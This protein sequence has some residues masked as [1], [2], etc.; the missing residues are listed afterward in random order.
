MIQSAKSIGENMTKRAFVPQ[1]YQLI[2]DGF[3]SEGF[4]LPIAPLSTN[5]TDVTIFYV[6]SSG[7][8]ITLAST[9]YVID[10][11]SEPGFI[12]ESY[13]NEWPDTYDQINAVMVQYITG[14]AIT[15]AVGLP[16]ASSTPEPI[17]TWIKMR[18]GQM[19]EFREPIIIGTI[20]SD[21]KRDFVDGLLDPY[22]LPT[23]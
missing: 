19:Y 18:V 8:T 21:L 7:S 17:K 14:Y 22:R 4:E 5:S 15:T 3:P 12:A 10:S 1:T 23:A 20:M 9:M 16:D 13:N 6:D 2:M 11:Y